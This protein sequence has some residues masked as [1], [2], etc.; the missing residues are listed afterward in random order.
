MDVPWE[1][2]AQSR[3][4]VNKEKSGFLFYHNT[5]Q[6]HSREVGGHTSFER[7]KFSLIYLGCLIDHAK[8]RKVHSLDLMKRV[9]NKIQACKKKTSFIWR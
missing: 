3:Q 7:G 2:E 8:K 1:Y 6:D 9:H 5:T 4:M